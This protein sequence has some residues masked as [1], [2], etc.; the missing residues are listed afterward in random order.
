MEDVSNGV[1][2]AGTTSSVIAPKTINDAAPCSPVCRVSTSTTVTT[3]MPNS[4][5]RRPPI[6]NSTT[7]NIAATSENLKNKETTQLELS[8]IQNHKNNLSKKNIY[9]EEDDENMEEQNLNA[10]STIN[11]LGSLKISNTNH[12]DNNGRLTRTSK[13]LS[14]KG[15]SYYYHGDLVI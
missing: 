15:Y 2:V 6:A 3:T 11:D 12:S 7:L 8:G 5:L 1:V 4:I 13:Q 9:N 14:N 10:E